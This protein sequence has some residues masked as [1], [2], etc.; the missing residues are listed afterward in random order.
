MK[1]IIL[2]CDKYAWIVPIC[3][4]FYKKN[5]PDNPY[6]HEIVTETEYI[7]GKVFYYKNKSWASRL[8]DHLKQS[9]EDKFLF[10]PEEYMIKKKVNTKRDKVA[11]KL[12]TDD[13]G[14]VRL[15]N[16]PYKY[17][18]KHTANSL[19][20]KGF[21]EYPL[22]DRFSMVTHIAFF[23]KQFLLDVLQ[24]G[25]DIH[26][27][28][29]NGSKRLK[30]LESKW[31]IL[32]PE[33]NIIDYTHNGGLMRK[34]KL[35]PETLSWILPELLELGGIEGEFYRTIQEKISQERRK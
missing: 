10:F 9:R 15:S 12:C 27:T 22:K 7:D 20:I 3:L 18:S 28:E 32:W 29:D 16:G 24:Y 26:Q 4:Y 25:E 34:G 35:R 30:K 11:E 19:S 6:E 14:C 1:V 31:R 23:Q 5:W 13:V 2:T 17:F 33:N 8:I 21:R